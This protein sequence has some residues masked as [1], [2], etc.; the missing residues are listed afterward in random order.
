M[1]MTIRLTKKENHMPLEARHAKDLQTGTPPSTVGTALGL[2]FMALAS[3]AGIVLGVL[4]IFSTALFKIDGPTSGVS[5]AFPSVTEELIFQYGM[6]SFRFIAGFVG[7][8]AGIFIITTV[9]HAIP[10]HRI[11]RFVT[12]FSL[13]VSMV[14]VLSLNACGAFWYNDS[15]SLVD[16]AGAFLNGDL[17]MFGPTAPDHG[18]GS[19][20][21]HSYYS[22]YPFQTGAMLWFVL[23]FAITGVGNI[24]G[25]QII[26]AVLSAG[27]AWAIWKIGERCGIGDGA[28]RYAAVLLIL[29]VP[30]FTSSSFVYPNTAGLFLILVALLLGVQAMRSTSTKRI[31]VLSV[32]AYLVA[33]VAMMVKG[34]E[35]IFVI[36]LTLTMVMTALF[37][38]RYWLIALS[39]VLF[40]LSHV[41]SSLSVTIV[42][43][44]TGQ[45]FGEGL[46]QLSWIAIG[47][48]AGSTTP[49]P[50]WW[51]SSALDAYKQTG[52][53]PSAQSAVAMQ[54]ITN[55]LTA[56]LQDPGEA[57]EFFRD[58]LTSEWS[59]PTFA[60]F[61]YAHLTETQA[62]GPI[63]VAM[64]GPAYDEIISFENVYQSI[65]YI[66]AAVGIIASV[67][68]WKRT[69][70]SLN[71]GLTLLA[72]C[73]LGGFGCFLLW[74]A[75]SVYT[76]PFFLLLIPLA[77]SGLHMASRLCGAA[78]TR[79]SATLRKRDDTL[80]KA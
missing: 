78:Y 16:S 9:V 39:C 58:K 37:K 34:T 24:A 3:V 80:Q 14:W 8:V 36:A 30:L 4:S 70:D 57:F 51:T 12:I 21:F 5:P 2:C 17:P 28:L 50:G 44:A 48:D 10:L 23:V 33:T 22:W 25:F 62:P 26:N 15:R 59:E 52:G 27:I 65:I 76:L 56:F 72:L 46:P 54:S 41:L 13:V 11:A 18:E 29:C 71:I 6:P 66:F 63:A 49:N 79:I 7:L 20:Q 42:E 1:Q 38:R 47:L 69:D 61:Y 64:F 53:D 31:I 32:A 73:F 77:A 45:D 40:M 67:I 43:M 75:K 19:P 68:R 55:S 74:E 35:I 60:S